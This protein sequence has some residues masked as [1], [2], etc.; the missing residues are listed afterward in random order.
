MRLRD[1]NARFIDH[2]MVKSHYR[3]DEIT[4]VGA[5]GI[6][7]QCPACARGLAVV[8]DPERPGHRFVVGAHSISVLFA[9]PQGVEPAPADAGIKDS[10]GKY[11]RWSIVSGTSLDDL[12]LSP[13]IDCSK[14]W[15]DEKG[16]EHPSGCSFHGYI[17]NGDAA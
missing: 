2:V 1:L 3:R 11:P 5:Q 12:T 8:D 13:S 6:T 16:V 4:L 15:K 7:F 10:T 17:K 9:N 14:P